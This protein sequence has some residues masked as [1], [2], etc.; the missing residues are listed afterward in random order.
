M[1]T[2]VYSCLQEAGHMDSLGLICKEG[3]PITHTHTQAPW[4]YNP[5]ACPHHEIT[6]GIIANTERDMLP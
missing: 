5:T 3:S 6:M 1:K 2:P 4:L